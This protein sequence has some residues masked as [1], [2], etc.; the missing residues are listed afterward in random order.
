MD[1]RFLRERGE[2]ESDTHLL[3]AAFECFMAFAPITINAVNFGK[4]LNSPQNSVT[5]SYGDDHSSRFFCLSLVSGGTE[6]V[7]TFLSGE[8]SPFN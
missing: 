7:S 1:D 3:Q 2:I 4:L 6:S 5:I 8:K